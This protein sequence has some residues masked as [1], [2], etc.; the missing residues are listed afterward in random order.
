MQI[1]KPNNKS[2]KKSESIQVSNNDYELSTI[3]SVV[4]IIVKKVKETE[5]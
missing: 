1:Y 5:K 3:G 4:R 2:S